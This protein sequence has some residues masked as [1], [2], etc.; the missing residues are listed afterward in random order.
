M[1]FFYKLLRWYDK[2]QFFCWLGSSLTAFAAP[3]IGYGIYLMPFIKKNRD[4]AWDNPE[5][6]AE[7]P[8]PDPLTFL[9]SGNYGLAATLLRWVLVIGII[10]I[11]LCL[12]LRICKMILGTQ[13]KNVGKE[14]TAPN[15]ES[16]EGAEMEPDVAGEDA[17]PD[18]L[19]EDED[20]DELDDYGN[21]D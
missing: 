15:D 5:L 7:R 9:T 11:I 2:F 14:V 17:V 4:L 19:Y 20:E 13:K 6:V 18:D 1:G 12:S 16:T 21:T 10:L 8:V 3:L